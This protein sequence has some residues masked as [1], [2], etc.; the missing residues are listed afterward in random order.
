MEI[1]LAAKNKT[2]VENHCEPQVPSY[3]I[4]TALAHFRKTVQMKYLALWKSQGY[5]KG[6]DHMQLPHLITCYFMYTRQIGLALRYSFLE[7]SKF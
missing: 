4:E 5:F 7:I 2:E 1:V 3:T 6:D